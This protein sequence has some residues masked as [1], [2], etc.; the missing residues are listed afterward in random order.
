[1][2][3]I[4]FP[5]EGLEAVT[6]GDD[7]FADAA[8]FGI[9]VGS[10]A[11]ADSEEFGLSTTEEDIIAEIDCDLTTKTSNA[12][13]TAMASGALAAIDGTSG[14][15]AFNLNYR[16]LADG[17]HGG[18]PDVLKVSGTLTLLWSMLGDD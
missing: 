11:A 13:E 18:N 4:V 9:G 14:A 1:G 8:N 3:H 2:A 6:G 17:D 10:V 15:Y 5:A 16:T 12:I 7:G